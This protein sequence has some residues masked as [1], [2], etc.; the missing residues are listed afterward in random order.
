M[1]LPTADSHQK[2]LSKAAAFT[3]ENR[4]AINKKFVELLTNVCRRMLQIGVD[5]EEL[6]LFVVAL[7]P[8]G[9]CIPPLP[10]SVTKVFEAITHHGLWDSLHYSPLVQMA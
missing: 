4:Q 6:R 5:V 3:F 2:E 9:D 1:N 10:T 7:F 8:P